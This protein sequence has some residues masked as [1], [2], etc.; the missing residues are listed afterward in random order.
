M[1]ILTDLQHSLRQRKH[2]RERHRRLK[3]GRRAQREARAVRA[4]RARIKALVDLLA[5]PRTM[6]DAVTVGNIPK[7][8][9]AVAGYVNGRYQTWPSLQSL[10][11]NAR[12][13]SIAISVEADADVLDV[14]PGDAVN[15]EAPGWFKRKRTNRGFYTSASN[16]Q[17]LVDTLTA[18]G[19]DRKRYSLWTAHYTD[20]HVCGPKT[21]GYLHSTSADATQ[22]TTHGETVDE[23]VVKPSF[24]KERR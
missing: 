14:E 1:S 9:K 24:W 15:S 21:C 2:N 22:W 11:P 13:V 19:I 18:A 10:F 8:A 4:I 16:A 5:A 17:A 7:D 12:K 20:S 6:Y 3:H 23:S